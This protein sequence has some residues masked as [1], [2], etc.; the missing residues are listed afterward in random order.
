MNNI[1]TS[2]IIPVYNASR[3]II[4][5]LKS[6]DNQTIRNFEVIIIND[7]STDNSLDLIEN[8]K[9]TRSSVI[10]IKVISTSNKGVSAA[11]NIGLANSNG[12]FISFVDADDILADNYL[13]LLT[14]NLISNNA[15]LVFCKEVNFKYNEQI[16][17][18]NSHKL[19]KE[20]FIYK[21]T[22]TWLKLFL[23]RKIKPGIWSFIIDKKILTS[24]NLTFREGLHYSED[25]QFIYYLLHYS[26]KTLLI[27]HYLYYYRVHNHSAMSKFNNKRFSIIDTYNELDNFFK[28]N[29]KLFYKYF[30]FFAH[31]RI[32]W[33]ISWQLA[34]STNSFRNF[35]DFIKHKRIKF[36]NNLLYPNFLIPV[37]SILIILS[38]F[39]FYY[40][41]RFI[42]KIKSFRKIK[43]E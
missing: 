39:S 11:R 18:I 10:P 17:N 36:L 38:P 19:K 21:N 7:G 43:Y 23:F 2:I 29:N 20:T 26:P 32:L 9:N 13:E 3:F 35:H 16:N 28:I 42:I 31:S 4:D 40:L 15:S 22:L 27:N 25:I 1:K 8:Y 6:V 33:S 41:V 12:E 30:H 24:N 34:S 5:C 37:S 14:Y